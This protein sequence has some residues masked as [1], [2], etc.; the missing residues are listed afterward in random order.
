[1][2]FT[3]AYIRR[4]LYYHGLSGHTDETGFK[5]RIN[6]LEKCPGL[7]MVKVKDNGFI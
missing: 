1:V 5:C 2:A 3:I 4:Q 7:E 6:K